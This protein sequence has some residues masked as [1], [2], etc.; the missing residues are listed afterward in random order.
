MGNLPFQGV[1]SGSVGVIRLLLKD[2]RVDITL[3]D[4]NGCTPLWWASFMGHH[5]VIECL[6]A[7]GRDLGDIK[8]KKGKY[9]DGK[10]YTIL[11]I[12]RKY[13]KR[14]AEFLLQRFMGNPALT[15]QEIRKKLKFAGLLLFPFSFSFFIFSFFFFLFFVN[16]IETSLERFLGVQG[17]LSM[18]LHCS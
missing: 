5:E 2:P 6:I 4:N 1:V 3:G 15:R 12:A 7:S 9:D 17:G 10:D 16:Q 8:N 14:E 18:C 11:E 13:K